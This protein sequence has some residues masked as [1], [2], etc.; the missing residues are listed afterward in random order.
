MT[1]KKIEIATAWFF[2]ICCLACNL[3]WSQANIDESRET[4]TLYVDAIKGSDSNPGTSQLP[5][6][7]IGA[8]ATKAV[9]NNQ[10][11]VG[12]KVIIRAGTFRES[13][14][15]TSSGKDT[16]FPITFQA[17][18]TGT[19]IISGADVWTGWKVYNGNTNIY[20]HTWA[21][22]WGLCELDG[23]TG[24]PP[25]EQDIVRRREMTIVNGVVM[26]QVM[27]LS[28]MRV[29]TF[30]VNESNSTIYLWPPTGTNINTATVEIGMRPDLFTLN[31]KSNIVL[32]GLTFQYSNPCRKDAVVDVTNAAN[33]I[34]VDNTF[35]YWNNSSPLRFTH[36]TYMT[37]QDSVFNHNGSRG[38]KGINTKYDLWQNNQFNFNGWRGAQGVYYYWGAAG[39]HFNGA[40]DQT[41]KNNTAAYNQT[42]GFHWDTDAQNVT[43]DSLVAPQNQLA[44]GFIEQSE[45][46]LT[47]SNS[48]FC[49]GN[50]S[51]GTNNVGF[52]ARNS[53]NV[54]LTGNT[55]LNNVDQ[56]LVLG[57]AGGVRIT[58][59]ETGQNYNLITNNLMLTN[60]IISGGS[61][62]FSDGALG[63]AD[64]I[65]FAKNF[66]SD[67]NTW[68]NT[69]SKAFI[70]PVPANWSTLD[71]AGWKLLTGEDV[72]SVFQK[73][74]N[75]GTACNN[76]LPDKADFWFIMDAFSGYQTVTRGK[77]IT[78][79]AS[80]VPLKFTGTVTLASDGVQNI[81]GA[82]AS[83]NPGT[84]VTSGSSTFTVTTSPTTPKGSYNITLLATNASVTKTMTV[85]VTVQ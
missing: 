13:V 29:G 73:P 71:F 57:T 58:N 17:A 74:S 1:T 65:A 48:S 15:M 59:W 60:N 34:L 78:F 24:N 50:P 5:L 54:T 11:G 3:A 84:I 14:T 37:I 31:G 52:E 22:K 41:L 70:V 51:T 72:H 55:F 32:R 21:N 39:I 45:G 26:S 49:N 7:T 85:N 33:N 27:S 69:N 46:P 79:T 44:A 47:V 67:Y 16:T 80:V 23:G 18:T 64:W 66:N 77:S 6:K 82:T 2:A 62:V 83:F 12:T 76:I 68:W 81:P 25:P 43:A 10:A 20:T 38:A 40:H 4:A 56:L 30:Y 42:F 63:G 19:A 53:T 8:A 35:F 36:T 28:A 9:S 75:P 61:S